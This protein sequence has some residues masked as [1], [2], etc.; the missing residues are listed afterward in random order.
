MYFT[1]D[2]ADPRVYYAGSL[3]PS[4]LAYTTPL[5]LNSTLT[6]KSRVLSGGVWSALNE[7]TF[8]V[9]E[10]GVPLRLTEIHYNPPGGEAEAYEFVEL[11]NV[12]SVPLDVGGFSFQGITYS[13]P[14]GT[15]LAP[16]ALVVLASA[17][18][19]AAF[20]TR[21]PGVLVSGWFGGSLANGGERIAL[22]DREMRTVFA[23][24]Y[25]DEGGWPTTPDGG[26]YSLEVVDPRGDPNAPDNWRASFA[27]HGTPGLA[28]APPPV[29]YIVLNEVMAENLSAVP[30]AGGYP[31]WVELHNR[32]PGNVN[33]A[34]W[35]LTDSSQARKFVF[36]PNTILPLGGHLVVWCDS[37]TNAPGLHAGFALSRNGETVSLFDTNTNRVD[38]L[39]FGLQLADYSLGR[40]AGE[41]QLTLP[42]PG[43]ANT[44]APLAAATNLALNEWL[45][46][47]RPRRAGLAR[48]LQPIEQRAGRPARSVLQH[49]QRRVPLPRALLPRAAG[50]RATSRRG[51]AGRGST[52][53]QAARHRG[54]DCVARHGGD[55]V[56]ARQLRAAKHRGVRGPPAGWR[57]GDRHLQR[58]CQ[59]WR[60]QLPA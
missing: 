57:G 33:L 1:T 37:N 58:Q 34:G 20:A 35:S 31:D 10:L 26:S 27:P 2:G 60:E 59:P 4:A 17:A 38:A 30:S 45:A 50:L 16:G 19:P 9:G 36:P 22:L 25:D 49:R 28:P 56:R 39:T 55:R 12:G 18:N 23:V 15:L 54:H 29:S 52:G 46:R 44:A 43:A 21:Y 51:T 8:V 41:W 24:H 42:T 47:A 11:R 7:A 6:L 32:G 5:T 14:S 48:G 13:F 53:V 3:A 40:V